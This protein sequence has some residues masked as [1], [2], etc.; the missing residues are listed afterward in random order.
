MTIDELRAAWPGVEFV[1]SWGDAVFVRVGGIPIGSAAFSP[2]MTHDRLCELRA[3]LTVDADERKAGRQ[4]A[5]DYAIAWLRAWASLVSDKRR[6]AADVL[7]AV[8]DT[9]TSVADALAANEHLPEGM[10]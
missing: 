6:Q 8:C 4:E 7:F 2:A 9:L 5:T 3:A 1:L 10:R